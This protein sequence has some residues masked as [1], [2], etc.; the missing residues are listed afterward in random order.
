VSKT[1][2]R[3]GNEKRLY[4]S[5]GKVYPVQPRECCGTSPRQPHAKGCERHEVMCGHKKPFETKT[6]AEERARFLSAKDPTVR[7][8]A[9]HCPDCGLWHLSSLED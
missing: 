3:R 4:R 2:R 6:R 7:M 1:W 5:Q 8:R 9:Y